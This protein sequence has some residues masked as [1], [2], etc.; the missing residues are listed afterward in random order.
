MVSSP[1]L[2]KKKVWIFMT[3]RSGKSVF[4][5][6]DCNPDIRKIKF[7]IY[8]EFR[9]TCDVTRLNSLHYDILKKAT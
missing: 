3:K 1:D 5:I 4:N 8:P 7:K 2:I 6:G 9:Y